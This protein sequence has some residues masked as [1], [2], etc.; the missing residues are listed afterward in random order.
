[1]KP[2]YQMLMMWEQ[3]VWRKKKSFHKKK[4]NIAN[5]EGY[6]FK[7]EKMLLEEF[8]RNVGVA[9]CC[10]MNCCQ[11]FPREKTCCWNK[12]FEF[13]PLKIKKIWFWYSKK[14]AYWGRRKVTKIYHYS[15]FRYLWNNLISYCWSPKVDIHVVQIG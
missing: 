8:V 15:R 13:Y 5:Y 3:W 9:M 10:T 12:S 2:M 1:M 11:H 14:V 4:W 7:I 6:V